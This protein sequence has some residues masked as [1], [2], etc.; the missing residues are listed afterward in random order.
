MTTL[1][2]LALA[3]LL[4]AAPAAR[5]CEPGAFHVAP[6]G[7][8]DASGSEAA[9][10]A[11]LARAQRA[12]RETGRHVTILAP[13][14]ERL[15]ATLVLG[16]PDN[17]S[18]WTSCPGA[19]PTLDGGGRLPV[20]VTV[21]GA[22]GVTLD[23]LAFTGT[24]PGGTAILL[25][26]ST[27]TTLTRLSIG[28]VGYGIVLSGASRN[29]LSRNR[30][31]HVA[32]S[33]IEA[34]DASDA[35]RIEDN[36]IIDVRAHDTAGGGIFLHGTTGTL[37]ARNLVQDTRGMGIGVSNWDAGTINTDTR[38][39]RNILRN[40]DQHATDSGAIY[41][42]GRS[43]V[44]TRM[45]I[46]DNLVEAGGPRR[47]HSVGIYLDD[48]T[49]GV[50]VHGNTLH[51]AGTIGVQ[52]HGG[53]NNVVERN[54]V[55]VGN[56]AQAAMLFQSAPADTHP[57][58]RMDGNIVRAN[59]ILLAGRP[60]PAYQ[61][62]NGGR[63]AISRNLYVAPPGTL[64]PSPPAAQDTDPLYAAPTRAADGNAGTGALLSRIGLAPVSPSLLG[65]M[66]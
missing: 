40:V 44:D 3:A 57:S 31:V 66:R 28:H 7:R 19:P 24:A 54:I 20:L 29:T 65:P 27:E 30:I 50:A 1:R 15:G 45:V 12:M 64:R 48:S 43:Q 6:G 59:L 13:G 49:S 2:R 22:R 10:F 34:K 51:Q 33:G 56:T 61:E 4:L 32:H 36:T 9:P 38:V 62:I 25:A 16:A 60:R 14:T 26:G 11:T 46:A 52:I 5:A 63:P 39:E 18:T 42:L 55:D 58:G 8:D 41:V 37:I 21:G 53:R 17:L 23:G 35:N 47:M